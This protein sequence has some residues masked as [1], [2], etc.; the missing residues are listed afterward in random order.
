MGWKVSS[1]MWRKKE[2][3]LED[4]RVGRV[5]DE[6]QPDKDKY[7]YKFCNFDFSILSFL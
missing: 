2:K 7:K 1:K 6:D 3:N 4:C 5:A